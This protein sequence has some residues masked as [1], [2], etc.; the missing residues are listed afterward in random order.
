MP[1]FR[2]PRSAAAAAAGVAAAT[3]AALADRAYADSPFR[4]PY[5]SPPPAT[6]NP[7]GGSSSSGGF[8][9]ELLERGAKALR[10]INSSRSAKQVFALLPSSELPHLR[11][12]LCSL[13]LSRSN[14]LW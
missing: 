12:P 9:P 1:P 10:E 14:L 4:F 3:L 8:D 11:H 2:L 5:S 13:S 6:E 7:S